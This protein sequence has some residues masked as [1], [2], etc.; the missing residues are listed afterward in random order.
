MKKEIYIKILQ[1]TILSYFQGKLKK[2]ILSVK[3]SVYAIFNL[4]LE[5]IADFN[6]NFY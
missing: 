4:S 3:I 6:Y 2:K 1:N 5:F